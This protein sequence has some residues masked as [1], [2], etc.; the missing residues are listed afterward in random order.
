VP[1]GLCREARTQALLCDARRGHA[2]PCYDAETAGP[3]A[4]YGA[5]ECTL[6]GGRFV[7]KD[8]ET[9]GPRAGHEGAVAAQAH[10]RRLRCWRV[11]RDMG[12]VGT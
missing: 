9:A 10:V 6:A 5:V 7:F 2:V 4:G 1:G 3:R 12:V 8:A 11:V